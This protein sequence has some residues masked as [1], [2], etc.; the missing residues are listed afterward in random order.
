MT[1]IDEMVACPG[2]GLELPEVD[3]A[4]QIRHLRTEHPEIINA[5]LRSVGEDVPEFDRLTPA[6]MRA[7]VL[8]VQER[9]AATS[10]PI[11][12]HLFEWLKCDRCRLTVDLREGFP[13]DWTCT[14][15]FTRGFIDLCGSCSDD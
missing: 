1:D 3:S 9:A 14:G 12:E 6:L 8:M 15:D 4:A 10:G 5:R 7:R 11:E 13:E 2:C